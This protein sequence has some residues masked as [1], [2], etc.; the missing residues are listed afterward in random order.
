MGYGRPRRTSPAS[1]RARSKRG[2]RVPDLGQDHAER[3]IA[4]ARL[5]GETPASSP[6]APMGCRWVGP[7][8]DRR[9]RRPTGRCLAPTGQRP[10]RA[11][12]R[13]KDEPRCDGSMTV[14]PSGHAQL[15]PSCPAPSRRLAREVANR[16]EHHD[17]KG[18]VDDKTGLLFGGT[19]ARRRPATRRRPPA[20]ANLATSAAAPIPSRRLRGN[21]YLIR[22]LT[23]GDRARGHPDGATSRPSGADIE[24]RCWPPPAPASRPR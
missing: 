12:V 10:S 20:R 1:C 22:G 14:L 15:L 13:Q 23:H 19:P 21:Q 2:A 11:A 4:R 17:Q 9:R 5:I 16:D 7:W 8:K 3:L 18:R 24:T 6:A